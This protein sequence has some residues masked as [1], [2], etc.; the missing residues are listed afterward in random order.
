M[1]VGSSSF[2]L[3]DSGATA[4]PPQVGH[5]VGGRDPGIAYAETCLSSYR[6]HPKT[7][8]PATG[9]VSKKLSAFADGW[10]RRP[11]GILAEPL[12]PKKWRT[13]PIGLP[14]TCG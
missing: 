9:F 12:P 7:D 10:V 14:L 11:S 1:S 2:S 6:M 13:W 5:G 8:C 3:S 4:Q